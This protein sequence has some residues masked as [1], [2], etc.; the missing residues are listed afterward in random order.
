M[1]FCRRQQT[2]EPAVSSELGLDLLGEA[3]LRGGRGGQ[4]PGVGAEEAGLPGRD[5]LR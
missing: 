1:V 3:T 2:E 5:L 4:V